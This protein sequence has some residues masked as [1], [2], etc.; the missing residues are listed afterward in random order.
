M[1]EFKAAVLFE[2]S[3]PLE[4][5]TLGLDSP[6]THGQVLVRMIAST[7]CG[8][9]LLE[10]EGLKGNAKFMPHCLGHEG[11]GEVVEV[12]KG[13]STVSVG[14]LAI[15]HWRKGVGLESGP[16]SLKLDG[17]RRVGAGPITTFSELA[18]ISENR[19]TAVPRDTVPAIGALLG[20][21]LSTGFSVIHKEVN[22]EQ[23]DSVLVFG[24][25]GVGVSA[26][27]AAR[28]KG[29]TVVVVDK[30]QDKREFSVF[31]GASAYIDVENAD[32][33]TQCL[34]FNGGDL[35]DC[36]I[37]ATG[38]GVMR[39][40]L[41]RFIRDGGTG[42][43]LGQSS[44]NDPVCVGSQADLFGVSHGKTLKFSQGGSFYPPTDLPFFQQIANDVLP[45]LE[46][47]MIS[48][49]GRLEDVNQ[50]I[51]SMVSGLAG[52]PLIDFTGEKVLR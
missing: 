16:I 47:S 49:T 18:V 39:S 25:G 42:V 40:K 22:L 24:S 35:F 14:Q 19:L 43:F 51:E 44:P 4:L 6:L 31:N 11:F 32:W 37:E 20:C 38:V 15:A 13:V 41:A 27:I 8:S 12:G 2:Q 9:Q 28:A 5:V 7:I 10:I 46:T 45:A 50:L 3:R 1:I 17:S 23:G 30:G 48:K 36:V 33:E 29:L 34:D 26:V 52:R 21:A